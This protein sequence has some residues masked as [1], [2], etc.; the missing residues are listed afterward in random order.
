MIGSNAFSG[1]GGVV[2]GELNSRHHLFSS[3][4][5]RGEARADG[6]LHAQFALAPTFRR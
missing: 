2:T 1:L 6:K 4:D 5:R 3:R